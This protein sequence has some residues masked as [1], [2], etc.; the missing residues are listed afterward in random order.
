MMSDHHV[1]VME[2]R[3]LQGVLKFAEFVIE[4]P[5]RAWAEFSLDQRQRFSPGSGIRPRE[6]IWNLD[7]RIKDGSSGRI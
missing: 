6:G 2:E 1:E 4:S 3:E 7:R 5:A